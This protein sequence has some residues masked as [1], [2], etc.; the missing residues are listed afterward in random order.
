MYLTLSYLDL[1][2]VAYSVIELYRSSLLGSETAQ[3][4]HRSCTIEYLAEYRGSDVHAW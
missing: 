2:H 1:V 4:G 3:L